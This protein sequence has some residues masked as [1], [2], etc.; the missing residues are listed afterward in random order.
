MANCQHFT[1]HSK[2]GVKAPWCLLDRVWQPMCG[3]CEDKHYKEV[4]P[5][6]KSTKPMKNRSSKLSKACDIPQSVKDTVFKRD[7]GLC[8][9]C[10]Q[11]GIPNMHY[12]GRG[13]L[14]LGIEQNI[15]C[16]CLKCHTEYDNGKYRE[17]HG[18]TIKRHLQS[19]YKDWK[20]ED[21]I[22]RKWK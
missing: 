9:I 13:Q 11:A 17:Q 18:E 6:K 21:L 15:V 20:E 2:K 7:K 10:G 4:K 19:K 3:E 22:Y 5:M 16:G 14:G 12:I 1:Y 8:V